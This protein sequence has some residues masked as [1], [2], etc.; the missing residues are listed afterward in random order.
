LFG[1]GFRQNSFDQE[2][3]KVKQQRQEYTEDCLSLFRGKRVLSR[4]GILQKLW[5]FQEVSIKISIRYFGH[6]LLIA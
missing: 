2:E 5:S 4:W 3:T 6:F 1:N